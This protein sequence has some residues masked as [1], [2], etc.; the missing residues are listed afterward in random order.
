MRHAK[1]YAT[2][3]I[4]GRRSPDESRKGIVMKTGL[5]LIS[6]AAFSWAQ[7][8]KLQT[9][10]NHTEKPIV[11]KP[12]LPKLPEIKRLAS[13]TW[14]LSTHKLL[15]VVEKGIIVNGEFVAGSTQN[16]AV[17]PDEAFMEVKDEQRGLGQDEAAS[18]HELLNM[19]SLYC[20]E[21]VDWW[22]HGAASPTGP[23]TPNA[24]P[25]KP[26]RVDEQQPEADP[27]HPAPP[28]LVAAKGAH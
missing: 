14:D 20:V 24:T 1:C 19:L 6:L 15:W 22:E 11:E 25:Q 10:Q 5:L 23:K 7:T 12:A 4:R 21:S 27:P 3:K 9:D 13:V 28:T 8:E 16:Y 18:L 26:A 17:S 2:C